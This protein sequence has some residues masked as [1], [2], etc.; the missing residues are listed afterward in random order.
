MKKLIFTLFMF[1]IGILTCNAA[2]SEKYYKTIYENGVYSS[3][4]ISEDEFNSVDDIEL[5]SASVE[6]E[7]KKMSLSNTGT[8]INL[9]VTWKK[10]P[11]YKSYD[12]IAIMSNDVTFYVNSLVGLQTATVGGSKEFAHYNYNS[13]N[14]K[15]FDKGIGI[16]MN[17]I[18]DATYYVLDMTIRY[19]GSGLVYGNYRHAQSN[20]TLAQSQDYYLSNGNIV[21]NNSSISNKYDSINPV[22]INV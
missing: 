20:V 6:T 3:F 14:V 13:Q 9:S 1:T 18:N 10:T 12:V 5:L 11:K 22:G 16:S 4:E 8:S 19:Y 7:Y 2:T 15:I 17:L 21:F